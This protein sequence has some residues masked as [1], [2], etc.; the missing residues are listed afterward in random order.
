MGSQADAP[1]VGR[2]VVGAD[3]LRRAEQGLVRYVGPIARILVKRASDAAGSTDEF[4]QLLAAHIGGEVDR[5]AF[6]R[7]RT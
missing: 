2:T 5:E 1:A 7:A 6:L 3:E 4:W